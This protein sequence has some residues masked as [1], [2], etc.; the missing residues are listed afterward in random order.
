MNF[1]YSLLYIVYLA[2][3]ICMDKNKNNKKLFYAET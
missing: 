3:M 2:C 1:F